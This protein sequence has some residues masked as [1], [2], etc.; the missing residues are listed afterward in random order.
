MIL[1]IISMQEI[2]AKLYI[3]IITL[4]ITAS[5]S[6]RISHRSNKTK[7]IV[8]KAPIKLNLFIICRLPSKVLST[9]ETLQLEKL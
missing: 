1:I 5:I 9:K 2:M 3:R 7:T 6:K 4:I 8:I